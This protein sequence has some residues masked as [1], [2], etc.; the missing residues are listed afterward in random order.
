MSE[1]Q[2]DEY[3]HYNYEQ[4]KYVNS[5][6]SGKQ[7]SKKEVSEHQNHQDPNGHTRKIMTKLQNSENNKKNQPKGAAEK[8]PSLS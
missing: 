1:Q 7:R 3:E 2:I 4:D 6:H 8:R 5:G